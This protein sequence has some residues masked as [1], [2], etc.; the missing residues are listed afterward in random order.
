[1]SKPVKAMITEDLRGR[2]TGLSSA[3]VVDMTGM[4][5]QQQQGLRAAVRAKNGRVEVVKNS[6]ARRALSDGALAPL[7]EALEG[8]CALVTGAE[9]VIDLARTL[10]EA[11]K[12]FTNLKLKLAII[13]G[14]PQLVSV[15]ALSRMKGRRELAAE[16]AMLMQSP[17]RAIAA[18]LISPQGKIAGCL[19]AMAEKGEPAA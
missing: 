16:I 5:V 7:G 11:A 1:M 4:D 6:L 12:E 3:C 19:K 8:P 10:V 15:E 17:G 9:S 13:D 18:C 2:F 14:D